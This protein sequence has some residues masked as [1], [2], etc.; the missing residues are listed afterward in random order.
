MNIF[1]KLINL[2]LKIYDKIVLRDYKLIYK[3]K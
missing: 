1:K 2:N 3:K